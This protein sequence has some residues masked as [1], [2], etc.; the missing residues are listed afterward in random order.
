[1]TVAVTDKTFLTKWVEHLRAG[2]GDTCL[3]CDNPLNAISTDYHGQGRCQFCGITYQMSGSHLTE[4]FLAEL[5]LQKTDVAR[6]YCD[7]FD[8]VEVVRMYWRDTNRA[9]PFGCYLP[10]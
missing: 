5:G 8:A 3:V 6:R 10:V 2:V 9:V 1:M 4:E 7:C